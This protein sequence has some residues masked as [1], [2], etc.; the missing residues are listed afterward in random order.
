MFIWVSA[1]R[2]IDGRQTNDGDWERQRRLVAPLVNERTS[3]TLWNATIKQ[4][5]GFVEHQA[6]RDASGNIAVS[7]RTLPEDIRKL[8]FNCLQAISYGL[9]RPWTSDIEPVPKGHAMSF[10]TALEVIGDNLILSALLPI[11]ITNLLLMPPVIRK[12]GTA[13]LEF[14]SHVEGMLRQHRDS[15]QPR[16]I[17]SKSDVSNIMD[18]MVAASD[19]VKDE[20]SLGRLH[21]SEQ[22]I[23][24]NMFQITV[25]GYETLSNTL[26][27]AIALLAVH[28]E[29]QAWL[30]EEISEVCPEGLAG[31]FAYDE[32]Y[33]KL[34]RCVAL[35]VSQNPQG[36]HGG[37]SQASHIY[38]H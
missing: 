25:A 17:P 31:S 20:S 3:E 35:M 37:M 11:R 33:A 8:V 16:S 2:C 34:P 22:E 21:L 18:F 27:Y 24:G 6:P 26:T 10:S 29:V 1:V 19:K 23:F 38:S 5:E 15:S 4:A 28:S 13:K 14:V 36:P 7:G 30:Y 32:T 12:I 9:E